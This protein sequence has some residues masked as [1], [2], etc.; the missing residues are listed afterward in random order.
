M[1]FQNTALFCASFTKREVK[2]LHKFLKHT[3]T[4][5]LD[6]PKFVLCHL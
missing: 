1:A 4:N 6:I 3:S 5:K 2:N